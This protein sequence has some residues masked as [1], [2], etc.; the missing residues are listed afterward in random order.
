MH[1]GGH[2]RLELGGRDARVESTAQRPVHQHA[3]ALADIGGNGCE[4]ERRPAE[5]DQHRV[6]RG[7]EVGDRVE[8]GA[9]QID[10]H[11]VDVEP[12]A[13]VSMAARKR[14]MTPWYPPSG[15]GAPKTAEPATKVSAPA[16]ATA[17]M[18]STLMPPST[19]SQIG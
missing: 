17:A 15:S 14:W 9:I 7:G 8:Q 4:R 1:E 16:L 6:G 18:F 2:R 10:Q 19:S 12:R 11:R 3:G 5:L 13:H